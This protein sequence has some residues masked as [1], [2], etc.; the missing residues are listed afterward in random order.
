[1]TSEKLIKRFGNKYPE[2]SRSNIRHMRAINRNTKYRIKK[3]LASGVLGIQEK[4]L[5]HAM[6]KQILDIVR[7]ATFGEMDVYSF[8]NFKVSI[9]RYNLDKP[10][11]IW[12]SI[13]NIIDSFNEFKIP[14]DKRYKYYRIN[15][16]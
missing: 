16:I 6:L 13:T 12:L 4:G 1:M 10:E 2:Y 5:Q 8:P 11:D 7:N 9:F 3:D 15:L 14:I